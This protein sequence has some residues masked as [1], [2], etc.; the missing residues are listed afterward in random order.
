[1]VNRFHF[2]NFEADE[3]IK[4]IANIS[5]GKVL[6]RA[7]CGSTAIALIEKQEQGYRCSIDIYCVQGPFMV[8]LA[9]STVTEAIQAVEEK[10]TKQIELRWF[11]R[12]AW[13][14]PLGKNFLREVS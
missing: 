12:A 7:P 5:L 3:S 8:S 13:A 1:M 6:D 10:L 11:D 9:R 2:K 4:T 14:W